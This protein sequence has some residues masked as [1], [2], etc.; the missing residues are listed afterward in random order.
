MYPVRNNN[1]RTFGQIVDHHLLELLNGDTTQVAG[2]PAALYM[3][4]AIHSPVGELI[5]IAV[6]GQNKNSGTLRCLGNRHITVC[7]RL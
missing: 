4:A 6:D 3:P 7:S 2:Q 1:G 5:V